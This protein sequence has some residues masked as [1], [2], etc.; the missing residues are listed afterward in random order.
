MMMISALIMQDAQ[1][2]V[3]VAATVANWEHLM[4]LLRLVDLIVRNRKLLP[5]QYFLV[6]T[7]VI[8]K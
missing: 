4:F 6:S 5:S 1:A 8:W 3:S 2:I 7:N